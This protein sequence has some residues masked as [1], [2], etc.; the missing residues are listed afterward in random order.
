MDAWS[1]AAGHVDE[2]LRLV[3]DLA[4]GDRHRGVGVPTLDD[5]PAVDRDDVALLEDAHPG[6]A[7]HDHLV[8]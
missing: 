1:A 5:R 6:D 2:A 4:D 3:V 8:R 7:V